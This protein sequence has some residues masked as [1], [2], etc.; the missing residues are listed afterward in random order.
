MF[1]VMNMNFAEVEILGVPKFRFAC[2]VDAENLYNYFEYKKD[3]LEISVMEEGRIADIG[4][5]E[6][7][8]SR[9]ET[10]R[11]IY[12]SQMDKEVTA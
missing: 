1:W 4:I 7:L 3:F 10:Y 8:V 2:S 12:E 11:E 9:C 5:H 6:E